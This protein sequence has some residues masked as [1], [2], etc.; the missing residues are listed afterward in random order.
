MSQRRK[1]FSPAVQALFGGDGMV[2]DRGP[3]TLE[4][5]ERI[6]RQMDDNLSAYFGD[7]KKARRILLD[8]LPARERRV[9]AALLVGKRKRGRRPGDDGRVAS[10]NEMLLWLYKTKQAECQKMG[11]KIGPVIFARWLYEELGW[12]R[13]PTPTIKS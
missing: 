13:P 7:R 6:V 2:E 3:P 9:W 10:K 5:L 1:V 12:V 4:E 8:A 11:Q